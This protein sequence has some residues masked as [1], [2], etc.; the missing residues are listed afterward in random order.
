MMTSTFL[1]NASSRMSVKAGFKFGAGL[2]LL[3]A[4]AVLAGAAFVRS[5]FAGS[6][7]TQPPGAR[8]GLVAT[9]SARYAHNVP[10]PAGNPARYAHNVA[11]SGP[12]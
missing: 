5:W 7:S 6:R 1:A 9:A 12:T 8:A 11:V 3:A 10:N 4:N 2:Y